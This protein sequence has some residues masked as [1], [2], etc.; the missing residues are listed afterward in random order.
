VADEDGAGVPAATQV[1]T[2]P[3][4]PAVAIQV[5]SGA[6]ATALSK[7]PAVGELSHG[8]CRR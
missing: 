4:S 8:S 7:L 3:A 5:P 2:V 1:R 6:I